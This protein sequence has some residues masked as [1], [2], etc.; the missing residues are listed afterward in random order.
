MPPL[1]E[2][3]AAARIAFDVALGM[4]V[5]LEWRVRLG[6]VLNRE[7]RSVDHGSR[8]LVYLTAMAG[9]G[10]CFL[11]AYDLHGAAIAALRS[12]L[13][14]IGIVLMVAGIAIR[15]WAVWLLGPLFTTDV[16]VHRDQKVIETGPYRL[17]RHPAYSGL[18][19]T[20][21]GIGLALGNWAGLAVILLIPVVG[22]VVRVRVEERALRTAIG[23]PYE[24]FAA[25]RARLLPHVW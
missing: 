24:R 6:T 3:N 5:L 7:G 21:M 15:H 8:T 13:F 2:T 22:L 1:P 23:A 14:W 25:T 12:P 4:F 11:F 10:G 20:F 19:I 17:V 9:I 18:L 16:R